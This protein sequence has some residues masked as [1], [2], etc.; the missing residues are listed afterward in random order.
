MFFWETTLSQLPPKEILLHFHKKDPARF[1]QP[2]KF[3]YEQVGRAD[4]PT[5][6]VTAEFKVNGEV[7]KARTVG[8]S[9][10]KLTE[11]ETCLKLVK[12]L[13]GMLVKKS[14]NIFIWM[15]PQQHYKLDTSIM[16]GDFREHFIYCV[17]RV[18]SIINFLNFIEDLL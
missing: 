9:T 2:P 5:F 14:E 8:K 10:K 6:V 13:Q 18:K 11:A 4:K 15:E 16:E 7:I 3:L 12:H 1:P 17:E